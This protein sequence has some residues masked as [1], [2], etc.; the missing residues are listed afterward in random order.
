MILVILVTLKKEQ[1]ANYLGY[2][3]RKNNRL[4]VTIYDVAEEAGVSIATVSKVINNRGNMRDK[5]RQKVKNVMATLNYQPN[6]MASALMGKGTKTIGLLVN[7][8]SNPI[9]SDLARIIENRSH[10]KGYSVIIC[11]TD[12]NRDKELKYLKVL[13]NKQVEG[14][15]VGSSFKDKAML[16]EMRYHNIPLV[17]LT[18]MDQEVL[19]SKIAVDDYKGGYM[20]TEHLLEN[21]HRRIGL[22]VELADSSTKRLIGY[23]EALKDWNIGVDPKLMI[24]TSASV[25]KGKQKFHQLYQNN[26]K[27]PPTAIFTSNNQLAVGVI[28]AAKSL[29]LAIPVDLAIVSFDDTI[30]AET[31]EPPI[32]TIAQPIETMGNE[33]VDLLI[34][35]IDDKM[36][37]V[38]TI[39]H[40]PQLIVRQ[41]TAE[42]MKD[43]V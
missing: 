20:A 38:H 41:T 26:Y 1:G 15:I 11:N 36:N 21:G 28:A 34:K 37:E 17:M 9:F 10:E 14:L 27:N 39:M 12:D 33:V 7:D 22:I 24:R 19:A 8:I 18:H 13:R 4:K 31:T 16:N 32:T 2:L 3:E 43:E 35:E 25:A 29:E 42:K 40:K 23:K 6:M 5:T 30:L